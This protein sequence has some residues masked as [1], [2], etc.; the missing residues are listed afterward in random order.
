MPISGS[1][2]KPG[3]S[4]VHLEAS[5]ERPEVQYIINEKGVRRLLEEL[6]SKGLDTKM[7]E[8]VRELLDGRTRKLLDG[9]T[10][11]I[12]ISEEVKHR[13]QSLKGEEIHLNP[14]GKT[15][16]A[17]WEGSHYLMVPPP[18]RGWDEYEVEGESIVDRV[19]EYAEISRDDA[20]IW[21]SG[22]HM[23]LTQTEGTNGDLSV[24]RQQTTVDRV[25]AQMENGS[26]LVLAPN[27]SKQVGELV[28]WH[29]SFELGW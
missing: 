15:P 24:F 20:R 11:T 2:F 7:L 6:E 26:L 28:E 25:A 22:T 12:T 23:V 18:D 16:V 1:I 3:R 10:S 19:S 17:T 9:R 4:D 5:Q 27:V 21:L 14:A 8:K 13:F 29:Y